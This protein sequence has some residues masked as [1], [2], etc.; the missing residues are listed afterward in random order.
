MRLKTVYYLPG[1]IVA[2]LAPATF[3][4]DGV[5][6]I[7]QACATQTGCFSG[8][9]AGFPVTINASGSYRLTSN[10]TVNDGNSDG[11]FLTANAITVD[12][13]GFALNLFALNQ[14][15]GSGV[16]G[17]GAFGVPLEPVTLENGTIRGFWGWG[18]ALAGEGGVRVE[19]MALSFNRGGGISVGNRAMIVRNR[20][21]DNGTTSWV[22]IETGSY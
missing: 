5:L 22:G 7:N 1:L 13:N 21:S 12:F 14:G 11:L 3:A 8:D 18:I 4:T 6:E 16:D 17:A 15:T 20:L 2:C 9:T 10:L 19:D